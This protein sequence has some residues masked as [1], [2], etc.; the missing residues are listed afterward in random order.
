MRPH[1]RPVLL[2]PLLLQEV[3]KQQSQVA[4]LR[5]ENAEQSR[6]LRERAEQMEAME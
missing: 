6:L 1:P 3:Q 4:E 5:A 2:A